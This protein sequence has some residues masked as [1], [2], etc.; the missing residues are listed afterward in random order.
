MM[1]STIIKQRTLE[2][3]RFF[4]DHQSTVRA[5]AKA[6]SS[7]N[8]P[9]SKSTVHKDLTERLQYFSP[10]LHKEVSQILAKNLDERAIRC[11]NATKKKY[12]N[13]KL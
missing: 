11:G 5:T 2:E 8:Q 12:E 9:V 3:A 10:M 7:N 1:K 6:F 4:I 13:L